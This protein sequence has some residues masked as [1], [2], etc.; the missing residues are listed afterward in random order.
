MTNVEEAFCLVLDILSPLKTT[1]RD[2]IFAQL[3][4]RRSHWFT[5]KVKESIK[6]A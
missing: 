6:N 2:E 3:T 5:Q 4:E 1:E